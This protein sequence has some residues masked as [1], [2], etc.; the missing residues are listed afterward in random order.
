[1]QSSPQNNVVSNSLLCVDDAAVT[2]CIH[3]HTTHPTTPHLLEKVIYNTT[4]HT[5]LQVHLSHTGSFSP[6]RATTSVHTTT[7]TITTAR[8]TFLAAADNDCVW[9]VKKTTIAQTDRQTLARHSKRTRVV[10]QL[11]AP[12][13]CPK[14][15]TSQQRPHNP[16]RL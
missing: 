5:Y 15:C 13:R 2:H 1:M 4:E 3:T 8:H 16:A 12:D 6:C 10:H 14:P 7:T 9:G 11:Q